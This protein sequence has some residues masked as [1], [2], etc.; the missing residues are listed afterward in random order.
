MGPP[1]PPCACAPVHPRT[2]R[3]VALANDA[4]AS[5]RSHN[6]RAGAA[7]GTTMAAIW[8]FWGEGAKQAALVD[9]V[10]KCAQLSFCKR[11]ACYKWHT[12]CTAN[13]AFT[14]G[15]TCLRSDTAERDGVS[16]RR[17]LH[18]RLLQ[19]CRTGRAHAPPCSRVR[20]RPSR[21]AGH[22]PPACRWRPSPAHAAWQLW[23]Y[24][25]SAV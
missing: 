5:R 18:L 21:R 14:A 4:F 13:S 7:R 2:T 1:P 10:L 12:P 15:R 24:R 23:H 16:A 22:S 6:P 8:P 20:P 25:A 19:V 11:A 3:W 9:L 17:V